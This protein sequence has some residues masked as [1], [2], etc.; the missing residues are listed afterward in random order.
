[1]REIVIIG[2]GLA[3][4]VSSILL[5]RAGFDVV[6]FE[7]KPYPFHRVCG[8]YL[9]LEVHP[10]LQKQ[11]LLPPI[12]YPIIT[13]FALSSTS[14]KVSTT[15]LDLGGFGISRH[16][17]D[18]HLYKVALSEGVDIRQQKVMNCQFANDSFLITT[19]T[20]DLA[21]RYV[22]GAFGKRSNLDQI[23]NRSFFRKRSPYIGV[24][25]HVTSDHPIDLIALHN[26]PGG[27][28][29]VSQ[30]EN[31][32]T[33][34]CY[35]GRREDLRNFG[36]IPEMEANVLHQ[37]PHLKR[38]WESSTFH[39]DKPEVINEISFE[40]KLPVENHI[41]MCGDAAGMITPLCGNGMAM[42]IHSAKILSE[43]IRAAREHKW[44]REELERNYTKKWKT[45]FSN[46]LW[47]GRQVQRLFGKPA[48]SNVAV[49]IINHVKPLSRAI[50]KGT[51]GKVID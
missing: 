28:C 49:N 18:H 2:G 6:L 47:F 35:L 21:G 43:A 14:G 22:I 33:N 20:F 11:G 29:G 44:S 38:L 48:V 4:L 32:T 40:V 24:K 12:D 9:S 8:E 45:Q 42:A 31:S 10:F 17:L 50:I 19:E 25:Y 3:G 30:V 41:F 16:T 39:W 13:Q 23:M 46:R 34:M 27:Y 26:F 7:R 36:S 5:R 1:M 15:A 51:H 37:N